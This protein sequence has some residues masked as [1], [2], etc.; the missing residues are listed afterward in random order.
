MNG[1]R[2]GGGAICRSAQRGEV[3][4]LSVAARME[5]AQS[6]INRRASKY[7]CRLKSGCVCVCVCGRDG[8]VV[9]VDDGRW[10]IGR[11]TLSR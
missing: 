7:G 2:G 5:R 3:C 9:G 8:F 10:G 6:V 4:T 11:G 1:E